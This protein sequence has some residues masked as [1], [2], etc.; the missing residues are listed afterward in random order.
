MVKQ[1]TAAVFYK[2][3]SKYPTTKT[4]HKL[5]AS[6]V[7]TISATAPARTHGR[8][9]VVSP[10]LCDDILKYLGPRLH[11]YEGCD[12]VDI[13]PGACIWTQKIHDALKP[14]SHI[15]LEPEKKYYEPF[16]KPLLDKDATYQHSALLPTHSSQ[17]WSTY[18]KLF[19]TLLP[20]QKARAGDEVAL[21]KPNR[22]L[23]LTGN[24]HRMYK[25]LGYTKSNLV[26][27]ICTLFGHMTHGSQT[28]DL[29]HRNGIVKMLLWVPEATK[30]HLLPG[31]IHARTTVSASADLVVDINQVAG[32]ERKLADPNQRQTLDEKARPYS[33]DSLSAHRV[34]Q[35]M[36][37]AGMHMP[38]DRHQ[39][40]FG[41]PIDWKDDLESLI[42]DLQINTT[43]P[44][45]LDTSRQL[46]EAILSLEKD[47]HVFASDERRLI[48]HKREAV[49]NVH[50]HLFKKKLYDPVP[51]PAKN[52]F[53][54]F[55]KL[56]K[57][58]VEAEAALHIISPSLS[59]EEME[60]LTTRLLATAG[61]I[62]DG[63]HS[64]NTLEFKLWADRFRG[65]FD[66]QR[67]LLLEDSTLAYDRRAYE[68]LTTQ[69]EEFWP[70]IPLT[71]LEIDPM[72]R[73][74]ASD[75]T[76]KEQ[77]S[78]A[79]RKVVQALFQRRA[80]SV[81]EALDLMAAN[82]GE[83]MYEAV[84]ELRDPRYGGR[85]DPEDMRVTALTRPLLEKLVVAYLEWPFRPRDLEALKLDLGDALADS[86]NGVV[87]EN[88]EDEDRD[89][90]EGEG[91][92]EDEKGAGL[93]EKS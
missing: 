68:T 41:H 82:A 20:L 40:R 50:E 88:E 11:D 21:R 62:R 57:R 13:N 64:K 24:L 80:M 71:L 70:N 77:G 61:R 12:I 37:R 60:T 83:D 10:E 28:N 79:V 86:G 53:A 6:N 91:E 67:C 42:S 66:E 22:T 81:W 49:A 39:S 74:F 19:E 16:V 29:I 89:E 7:K 73:N 63:I 92:A 47:S 43:S 85:L 90:G 27:S 31:I 32:M 58:Q 3:V 23:L 4:L 26:T 9:D 51:V 56:S 14:R 36:Q 1:H 38:Q 69:A 93:D 65:L 87:D 25:I 17:Y 54:D 45:G 59:A 46:E 8:A 33:F 30:Q 52:R 75:I 5:F 18:E 72:E 78:A 15:L 84:P 44:P 34:G 55:V 48:E 76:T 2:T 35:R